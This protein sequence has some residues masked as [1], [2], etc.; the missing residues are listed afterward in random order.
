MEGE[1][2]KNEVLGGTK[3]ARALERHAQQWHVLVKVSTGL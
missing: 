1:A 2:E 3:S